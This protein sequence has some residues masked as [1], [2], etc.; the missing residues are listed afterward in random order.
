VAEP[1]V[2]GGERFRAFVSYAHADAAHAARLQRRLEN[3][4]VPNALGEVDAPSAVFRDREDLS[5]ASDLS[6]AVREALAASRA[7][8]V[9]CTPATP[10]S[11]W[12]A[13]EIELFR[14]LHPDR[15]VLAALFAGEPADAFPAALTAGGAEPLAA[16]FRKAGDGDRLAFLK[17]VAGVLQVPLDR[18]IQRDAQRRLRRVM[19]VTAASLV[20]VLAMG[21]MTVF[22]LQSRQQAITERNRA[23]A[24][25]RNTEELNRFFVTDFRQSLLANGRVDIA[26]QFYPRV[27]AY[28]REQAELSGASQRSRADCAEVMVVM[29][30][31]FGR[32]GDYAEAQRYFDAAVR[33]TGAQLASEPGNPEFAFEHAM[34][35]NR[36]GLLA[37]KREDPRTAFT[38]HGEARALL[39]SIAGWGRDRPEWLQQSA[40]VHG[41]LASS[42][43]AGGGSVEA[44]ER[45]FAAAV[46]ENDALLR[47]RPGDD[48]VRYDQAFQLQWLA[49]VKYRL[50]KS[51]EGDAA[52]ARSLALVEALVAGDPENRVWREQEMQVLI[53]HVELLEREGRVRESP[54][55]RRRAH[56]AAEALV[57][58]DPANEEWKHYARRLAGKGD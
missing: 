40:Y 55:Y 11:Q 6:A 51:A 34:G 54:G 21:A 17:I 52:A 24:Q 3:Y 13:R 47:L 7:L 44:A 30:S 39:D 26:M 35:V 36:L 29:G 1:G 41:N 28:C 56:R 4:R 48:M 25:A 5:A 9:V 16:D 19:A 10:R 22:A 37:T 12:V 15:P 18:L 31:D 50:G 45:N 8:V 2:D 23:E 27:L 49:D 58:H 32:T 46:A 53:R 42:S 43:L 14:A 20:L 38:R 33:L 57:R